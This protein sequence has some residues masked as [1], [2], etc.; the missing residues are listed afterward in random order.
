MVIPREPSQGEGLRRDYTQVPDSR[1]GKGKDIVRS[2][3]KGKL[4]RKFVLFVSF[5]CIRIL[6]SR[7]EWNEASEVLKR[8]K[9]VTTGELSQRRARW[10]CDSRED[11]GYLQRDEKTPGALLYFGIGFRNWMR[12]VVVRIWSAAFGR[13]GSDDE[14]AIFQF[15]NSNLPRQTRRRQC[16][17]GSFNGALPL[18]AVYYSNP[19]GGIK[20][21][22]Y[23]GT[24]GYL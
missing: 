9:G 6:V 7:C 21:W 20:I 23:A 5:A 19:Q 3:P 22:L 24:S 14:T 1:F 15:L 11:A 12:S 13:R 10:K 18:Q 8:T 2:F 16:L 17:K 4:I